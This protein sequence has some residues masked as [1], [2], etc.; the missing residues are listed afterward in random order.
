MNCWNRCGETD[1]RTDCV[2]ASISTSNSNVASSVSWRKKKNNFSSAESSDCCGCRASA[3]ASKFSPLR[4]PWNCAGSLR[5]PW[6][7][8]RQNFSKIGAREAKLGILPFGAEPWNFQRIPNGS[9]TA[10][11][12]RGDA[13][14]IV[15]EGFPGTNL[16]LQP[17]EAGAAMCLRWTSELAQS[18]GRSLCAAFEIVLDLICTVKHY[19]SRD[20]SRDAIRSAVSVSPQRFQ[21]FIRKLQERW[22]ESVLSSGDFV[23]KVV[24]PP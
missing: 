22:E 10:E 15:N 9:H 13:E 16:R 23:E 18:E 21:Q 5:W 7:I 8:K 14:R 24:F 1:C 3:C 2:S 20:W 4:L 12:R 6:G 19:W 17:S 11:N